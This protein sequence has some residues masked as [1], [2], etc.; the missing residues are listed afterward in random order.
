MRRT[1]PDLTDLTGPARPAAAVA[2]NHVDVTTTWFWPPRCHIDVVTGALRRALIC[3][4][5]TMHTVSTGR[6]S[7]WYSLKRE[8]HP[9][10]I[11]PV[12]AGTQ[13]GGGMLGR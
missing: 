11:V 8:P 9:C 13:P 3:T 4:I 6:T 10:G 7:T 2:R 12:I 1:G 5:C